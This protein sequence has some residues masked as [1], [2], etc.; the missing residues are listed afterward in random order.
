VTVDLASAAPARIGPHA[1]SS[2]PSTNS[3]MTSDP[4]FLTAQSVLPFVHGT[5]ILH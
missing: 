3:P 2:M 4:S 5:P 1:R